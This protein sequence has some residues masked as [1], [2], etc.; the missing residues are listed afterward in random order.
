MNDRLCGFWQAAARLWSNYL[1]RGPGRITPEFWRQ[2]QREHDQLVD[3]LNL[4]SSERREAVHTLMSLAQDC[5]ETSRGLCFVTGE[6]G[7]V[8][9][10]DQHKRFERALAILASSDGDS[11]DE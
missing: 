8:P 6:A 10:R 4:E 1:D 11:T 7:L 5:A 9:R 3:D 2:L